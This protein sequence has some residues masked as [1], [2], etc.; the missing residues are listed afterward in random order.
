M[1]SVSGIQRLGAQPV[2]LD[3]DPDT[4]NIDPES[5]WRTLE[6]A[7]TKPKA[8]IVV[9]LYGQSADLDPILEICKHFNVTV[10][11]D[12]AQALGALYPCRFGRRRVGT[13]GLCSCFSFF[14]T[15]PLGGMGDGGAIAT[16]DPKIAARLRQLRQHG[17]NPKEKY[18]NRV[19][20]IN[21]RLDAVQAAV[22]DVKLPR[23]D[24]WVADVMARAM[25]YD[26]HL[27][28]KTPAIPLGRY[29]HCY[30]LYTVRVDNRDALLHKLRG[31]GIGADIYFPTVMHY[32]TI[33][34][35]GYR[36]PVAEQ[37]VR[38]VLSLPI[39]PG[40]TDEEQEYVIEGVNSNV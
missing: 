31:L 34:N 12:C 4:F 27:K 25:I 11:E 8:L 3:I 35:C 39:F 22:L 14:P 6:K 17:W 30:H 21:S 33:F 16:D 36:L 24:S 19:A 38:E 5:L 20:G 9:H 10:I 1:P 15:K 23:L 13:F 7:E 29:A 37:A 26:K 28:V 40:M 2:F 18:V 32:Q